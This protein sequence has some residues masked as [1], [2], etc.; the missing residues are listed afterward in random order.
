MAIGEVLRKVSKA[1]RT[2]C[3]C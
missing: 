1:C 3:G 2:V